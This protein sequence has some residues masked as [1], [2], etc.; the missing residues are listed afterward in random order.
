VQQLSGLSLVQVLDVMMEFHQRQR[1]EWSVQIPH[2]LAY[3]LER[4][5]DLERAQLIIG[6][7]LL[8]SINAGIASPFQ[9]IAVSKWRA[10]LSKVLP[11]WRDGLVDIGRVSEPWVRA[12]IRAMSATVS[13]LVGPRHYRDTSSNPSAIDAPQRQG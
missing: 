13:R 11:H 5:T 10:E 6:H 8:M 1:P 12:R 4:T 3:I 2:I 9:R 7:I